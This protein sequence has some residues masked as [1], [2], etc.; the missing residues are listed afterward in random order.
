MIHTFYVD[1]S[2][3]V[4]DRSNSIAL[5]PGCALFPQLGQHT[6]PSSPVQGGSETFGVICR[7]DLDLGPS[8][9]VMG[10]QWSAVAIQFRFDG[11][12]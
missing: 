2:P 11:K 10:H 6:A 8:E 4:I 9:A 7:E 1:C 12:L 3:S 5:P